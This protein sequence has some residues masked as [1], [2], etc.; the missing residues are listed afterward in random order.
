VP[1]LIAAIGDF[2]EARSDEPKA[3][4]WIASIDAILDKGGRCKA[5]LE[6]MF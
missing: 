5:V 4:V 3:F 1:D 6:T 2:L